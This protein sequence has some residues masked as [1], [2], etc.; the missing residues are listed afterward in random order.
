M[1]TTYL[2]IIESANN[3][4]F[5]RTFNNGELDD[6]GYIRYQQN[7]DNSKYENF[8]YDLRQTKFQNIITY[9]ID[10]EYQNKHYYTEEGKHELQILNRLKTINDVNFYNCDWFEF[11]NEFDGFDDTCNY[12]FVSSKNFENVYDMSNFLQIP[13]NFNF[14]HVWNIKDFDE[15]FSNINCYYNIFSNIPRNKQKDFFGEPVTIDIPAIE[16]IVEHGVKQTTGLIAAGILNKERFIQRYINCW[17]VNPHSY[18]SKGIIM[19]FDL[20]PKPTEGETS[21]IL[22]GMTITEQFNEDHQYRYQILDR[23]CRCLCKY[24]LEFGKIETINNNP[25]TVNF[26]ILL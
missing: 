15:I 26:E 24:G 21:V 11:I 3:E 14:F 5:D 20:R 4:T 2:F 1:I 18:F 17:M 8:V 19:E 13:I 25:Y 23:M 10:R 9:F 16:W 12:I 22:K 6:I 7:F